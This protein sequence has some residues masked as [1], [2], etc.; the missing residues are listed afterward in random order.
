MSKS[1]QNL[2]KQLISLT[3][4]TICTFFEIDFS[5]LQRNFEEI[6][7]V[8][9]VNLGAEP[10]Y[11]FC[12]MINGT[13]PMVWQGNE[14][15]PLPISMNGFESGADG[16]LPRPKLSIAN[17]EGIFSKIVHSNKDFTNC[18]V[19]RKRTFA[20]F[21]DNEN[22]QN[23]NL[24]QGGNNPFGRA[25]PNSHMLD[26]ICFINKKT[27]ENKNF[28]QF[29]LVSALELEDS[30]VPARVI[31]SNYCNGTY[32]CSIGCKYSGAPIETNS[33]K[34][35]VEGVN[36]DL[37]QKSANGKSFSFQEWKSDVNEQS[38]RGYQKNEV[39]KIVEKHNSEDPYKRAPQVFI[40]IK[41]HKSAS[42]H[43]PFFDTDH[44]LRDECSKT[45]EACKKR[46]GNS[47]KNLNL[48]SGR[49]I[50]EFNLADQSGNIL[51]FGGFPGTERFPVE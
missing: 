35:L 38:Q 27:V 22:F 1:K 28:I 13:N 10:I 8:Y 18:K 47:D 2:N 14:Y 33:G 34:S 16:R 41:T 30:F 15:Q 31:L 39:V 37:F 12:P 5:N 49:T 17:P 24:N 11:R 43:H 20:R 26:D 29:E 51:R 36:P 7:G 48:E 9:G 42:K 4:D 40:C 25:D 19:T 3:A 50:N 44:W 45:L 46:F 6:S 21:L 32:R 23:K